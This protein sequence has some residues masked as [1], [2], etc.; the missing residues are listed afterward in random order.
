[1]VKN[2]F[3]AEFD[4]IQGEKAFNEIEDDIFSMSELPPVVQEEDEKGFQFEF[5]HHAKQHS[6]QTETEN[7]FETA[8]FLKMP[9]ISLT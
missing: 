5:S 9:Q 7:L 2:P 4:Q 8:K 3:T 6:Q 1:M